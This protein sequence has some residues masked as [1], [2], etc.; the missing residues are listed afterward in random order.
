MKI[1]FSAFYILVIASLGFGQSSYINNQYNFGFSIPEKF[2]VTDT[3]SKDANYLQT[4]I[5]PKTKCDTF[6][7]FALTKVIKIPNTPIANIVRLFQKKSTIESYE[8]EFL[9]STDSSLCNAPR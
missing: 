8:K 3:F 4:Y 1:I 5:C 2:E 7:V 9:T 6:G